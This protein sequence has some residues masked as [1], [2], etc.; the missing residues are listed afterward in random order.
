MRKTIL[1]LTIFGFGVPPLGWLFIIIY[2]GICRDFSELLKIILSPFL[3]LYVGLYI[4]SIAFL[5]T[6]KL[7]RIEDYL[8]N[9]KQENT[10]KILQDVHSIPYLFLIGILLYCIIGPNTG[11][12]N[13]LDIMDNTEYLLG[14][15]FGIPFIILFGIPFFILITIEVEKLSEK[16]QL[17]EKSRFL[18][19]TQKILVVQI[20]NSAGLISIL[21]LFAISLFLLDSTNISKSEFVFKML[22]IA[23]ISGSVSMFNIFVLKNQ[24]TKP[25]REM[26]LAMKDI[27]QGEGNL[28]SRV[29]IPNRD[30]TGYLAMY[31]NNFIHNIESIIREAKKISEDLAI[32]SGEQ[33]VTAKSF[34][35]SSQT[36][37]GALEEISSTIEEI[38]SS[39]NITAN[40]AKNTYTNIESLT[41]QMKELSETISEM[42][43]NLIETNR[44][45]SEI[46]SKIQVGEKSLNS[47]ILS[48]NN[49]KGSSGKMVN[50]I[51]MIKKIS[52]KINLLSLNA[53]IEAARAGESGRG[54]AVV[55]DE[56][57]KLALQTAV[58]LKNIDQ[59]VKV[60]TAE[61]DI[62]YR[63]IE[64][65]IKIF[66]TILTGVGTVNQK[67]DKLN[68]LIQTQ[69]KIDSHVNQEA[70]S[71]IEKTQEI[72]TATQEQKEAMRE[73]SQSI[74]SI[75]HIT[76]SLAFSSENL[77]SNAEKTSLMANILKE[78][79]DFFTVGY[80]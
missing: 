14:E 62:G 44:I 18:N 1:G 33:K 73:I 58:S 53:A 46:T 23:F 75:N 2:S 13:A 22:L 80:S 52:D 27:S 77:S 34:S 21:I 74:S 65:S 54:F 12:V 49:I 78:K 79:V 51:D 29:K 38:S 41:G 48:M 43:R 67:L 28:T 31:F 9:P 37:A 55:A 42:N 56:V 76:E 19:L 71:S 32:S 63:N 7:D 64:D 60:N 36:Q 72:Q 66:S 20:S 50:I 61:I 6:K 59:L 5:M 16:I 57:S 70:R 10:K 11:L 35:D 25:I 69:M 30:D 4:F 39:M 17:D 3:W 24:I 26:N 68:S 40:A 8:K 47:M 15:L 45:T